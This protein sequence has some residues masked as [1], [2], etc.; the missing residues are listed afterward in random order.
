MFSI[1]A[2]SANTNS[3]L[4]LLQ[5]ISSEVLFEVFNLFRIRLEIEEFFSAEGPFWKCV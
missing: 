4:Y 5:L 3:T 1:L 2:L